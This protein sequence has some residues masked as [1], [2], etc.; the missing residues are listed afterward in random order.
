MVFG[1]AEE[2]AEYEFDDAGEPQYIQTHLEKPK[3]LTWPKV[4]NGK[5]T[6]LNAQGH[7][8]RE[9]CNAFMKVLETQQLG[10]FTFNKTALKIGQAFSSS[11]SHLSLPD[12][13]VKGCVLGV[14][15]MTSYME[16]GEQ[17]P[18]VFAGA[19]AHRQVRPA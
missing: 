3:G 18:V 7:L 10:V 11:A 14:F 16:K 2:W 1:F 4:A 5:K 12:L 17:P 9:G 15:G 19:D 8:I 13:D 6:C